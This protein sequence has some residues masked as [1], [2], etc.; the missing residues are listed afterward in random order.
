MRFQF[1]LC[2][3]YNNKAMPG[4]LRLMVYYLSK[5][6]QIEYCL[7]LNKVM[8]YES[9]AKTIEDSPFHFHEITGP[10]SQF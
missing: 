6:S 3:V 2:I 5:V 9:L 10:A 1:S 4:K 8:I 7:L